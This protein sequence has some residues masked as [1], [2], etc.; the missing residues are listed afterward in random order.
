MMMIISTIGCVE[1][2]III[3][4]CAIIGILMKTSMLR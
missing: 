2:C 1:V 4:I 3:M